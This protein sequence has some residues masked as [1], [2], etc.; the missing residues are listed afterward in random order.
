MKYLKIMYLSPFIEKYLNQG[1]K[2]LHDLYFEAGYYDYSIRSLEIKYDKEPPLAQKVLI[3]LI[4]NEGLKYNITGFILSGNLAE[5]DVI[6]QKNLRIFLGSQLN[7]K[8]RLIIINDVTEIYKKRGYWNCKI[9][10]TASNNSE[11]GHVEI[12]VNID[13]GR[14]YRL[15]NFFLTKQSQFVKA[16]SDPC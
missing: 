4:L 6:V 12:D 5:L 10:I 14:K 7:S 16:F 13:A 3:T 11:D 2:Q 15:N 8:T 1:I 9:E